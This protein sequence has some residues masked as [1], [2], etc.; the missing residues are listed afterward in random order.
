MLNSSFTYLHSAASISN[1]VGTGAM[2]F[3]GFM[4]AEKM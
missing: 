3:Y 2:I 4:L 1:L